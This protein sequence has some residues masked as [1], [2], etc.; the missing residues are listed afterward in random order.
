[1]KIKNLPLIV[2]ISLPILL[3]AIVSLVIFI[4]SLSIKPQYSFIYIANDGFSDY[5]QFY[6]NTYVIEN[7]QIALKPVPTR[8]DVTFKLKGD[9]PILYFY[10]MKNNTSR[11]ISLEEAQEYLVDAG[12]SSP[13]GYTVTYQYNTDGIFDLFGSRG[14]N[15]EYIISKGRGS[16][17]LTGLAFT[18]Q[19]YYQQ[20]LTLV[21]WV[22]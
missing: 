17:K 16:K 10:D 19:N 21:G 8:K 18:D 3:I 2:G 9:S 1:M 13:D 4:P 22:K 11:K 7:E 14:N 15:G 5:D 6:K 20:N 12:P